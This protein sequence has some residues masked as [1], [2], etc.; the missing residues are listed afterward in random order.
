MAP[1]I[2]GTAPQKSGGI[3]AD[4]LLGDLPGDHGIA[5]NFVLGFIGAAVERGEQTESHRID[6]ETHEGEE[7]HFPVHYP[8][9]VP[10]KIDGTR[11]SSIAAHDHLD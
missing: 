3:H 5:V 9:A 8:P 4:T 6:K 1:A 7:E 11:L 2:G 10:R